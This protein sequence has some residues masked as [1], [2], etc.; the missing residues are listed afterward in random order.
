MRPRVADLPYPFAMS[1]DADLGPI[2]Y[3]VVAFDA[4]P[5]PT[6]G[7]DRV[8]ELADAG[9]IVVLDVE[10]VAKSADGTVG[11][12]AAA[13]VGADAFSG[14]SS[15]LIDDE[16]VALVADALA[17]GGVGVVVMYEDLT[18]LPALAAWQAEGATVVSEGP[19]V[20]DELIE[21]IDASE[22]R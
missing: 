16:D 20:V 19:V 5:V 13:E 18:L 21:A 9:R 8:R 2:N 17:P 15:G 14:A 4:A 1:F 11:T 3:V 12:V 10:F 7:L 6:G 22:S